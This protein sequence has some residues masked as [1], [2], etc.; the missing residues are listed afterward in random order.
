MYRAPDQK[1]PALCEL[2][3]SKG[4]GSDDQSRVTSAATS[5]EATTK[6]VWLALRN[7]TAD[8]GR[9]ADN[10]ETAMNQFAILCQQRCVQ[11]A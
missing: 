1:E 9:P 2:E 11:T 3:G 10:S 5:G 4:A 8:W 6:L 7:I